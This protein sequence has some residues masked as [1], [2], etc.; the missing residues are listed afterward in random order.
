MKNYLGRKLKWIIFP[1]YH[2]VKRSLFSRNRDWIMGRVACM[3]K[4]VLKLLSI[5]A[6][7]I[8][9]QKGRI[10]YLNN[11][12]ENKKCRVRSNK[13]ISFIERDD[14]KYLIRQQQTGYGTKKKPPLMLYMDSYS[15]LTDQNFVN[16]EKKWTF[17]ANYSDITHSLEFQRKFESEGLLKE[18]DLIEQYH[19]FFSFIRKMY[20]N[21]PIVYLHFPVKLDNREK[22][23]IRYLKIKEAIDKIKDE[24]Q[25]FY[26]FEADEKIVDW[27]EESPPELKDFPYHYNKETYQNLANQIKSSG[28]IEL[29]NKK[30]LLS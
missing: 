16:K 13:V 7:L 18:D 14:I 30:N 5:D 6:S 21:V 17:C 1:T 23:K 8:N 22:F 24:F 4:D 9:I 27:P 10:D 28:V 25:P 2:A 15:E 29:I 12:N 20:G 19:Q 3:G 26:S 11:V